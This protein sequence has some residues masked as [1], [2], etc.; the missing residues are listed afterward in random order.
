MD[1]YIGI[2]L[3]GTRIRAARFT[4]DLVMEARTETLTMDEN[5]PEYV[6]TRM[7]EQARAV[8]PENGRVLGVGVSAPGPIDPINGV[9]TS[10]PNLKG[11]HN[12]PL[13]QL[14]HDQL[15][16]PVHL[17]ND[18]NLAALAEATMGAGRGYKDV[19][20]LT[21]STGIGS[22]ILVDGRLIIGSA[23]LG[24]ECGHLIMIVE[25][26]H[27]STLEKEAA[28]PAIAKRA[29]TLIGQGRKSTISELAKG[30]MDSV[31]AKMVTKAAK[32]GDALALEIIERAG[33]IIG[34]GIV[35]L[36]HTFNPQ[37]IVLGGG[38][39]EGT[40]EMLLKPMRAAIE[41]YSLDK[42]YWQNLVIAPAQLGEN[43]SLIGAAALALAEAK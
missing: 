35:S 19:I 43:V 1:Y 25:N 39:A 33:K 36:L 9:I 11:W 4:P 15:D 26:D 6:L 18:A 38:V 24:A 31:D 5:G 8:F 21:I 17:G 23:G 42:P 30:D 34:C 14:L 40:G 41:A 16:V 22:G 2:D 10:P 32:E 27:V 7:V 37:I 13:R 20:F 3:G 29:V 12:V 28:G